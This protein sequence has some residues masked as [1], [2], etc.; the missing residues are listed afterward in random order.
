[1]LLNNS[2]IKYSSKINDKRII[3]AQ[4]K[5]SVVKRNLIAVPLVV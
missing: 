2:F 4:T 5:W 1:M 3:K